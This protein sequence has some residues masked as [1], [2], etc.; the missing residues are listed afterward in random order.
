MNHLNLFDVHNKIVFV[1]L[2]DKLFTADSEKVFLLR[3]IG[4]GNGFGIEAGCGTGRLTIP[5]ALNG[6]NMVGFD[7]DPY[8]LNIAKNKFNK[9]KEIDKPIKFILADMKKTWPKQDMNLAIIAYNTFLL[10]KS[11]NE[12]KDIL[13]NAF[14]SLSRNGKLIVSIKLPTIFNG[15][16]TRISPV[17]YDDK[18]YLMSISRTKDVNE[19]NFKTT[20]LIHVI[21]ESGKTNNYVSTW[22]GLYISYSEL[23]KMAK[24]IGFELKYA[25]GGYKAEKVEKN[26]STYICVFIKPKNYNKFPQRKKISI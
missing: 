13:F 16:V 5:L 4:K 19:R 8:I 10:C 18:I 3:I 15:S 9:L 17:Q 11:I 6:F 26:S 21:D 24:E 14:E 12:Q 25:Y 7:N 22:S 23:V 2:Y 20:Y 1:D